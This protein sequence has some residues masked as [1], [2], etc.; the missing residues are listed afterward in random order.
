MNEKT[1][2]NAQQLNTLLE[3][4][5]GGTFSQKITRALSDVA[6]GVAA[7]GKKGSVTIQFDLERIGE[8]NQVKCAHK[9]KYTKPTGKGKL[10][11]DN[12]DITPL[13]VGAGGVL[14]LFP[15]TQ[16]KLFEPRN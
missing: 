1:K 15:D 9:L 6:L 14:T 12:T 11:E 3:D 5:G 2:D 4:L 8:S 7:H 10:I 13:H 16:Q